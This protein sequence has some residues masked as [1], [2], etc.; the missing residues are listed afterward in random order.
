[1]G[2]QFKLRTST[3]SLFILG[4]PIQFFLSEHV[5]IKN[6]IW[7]GLSTNYSILYPS[8]GFQLDDRLFGFLE[9]K[10]EY[11]SMM[12][13]PSKYLAFALRINFWQ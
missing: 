9:L 7:L 8:I 10:S 1:M 2:K 5:I 4:A 12:D 13:N 11:G 6:R 3:Y